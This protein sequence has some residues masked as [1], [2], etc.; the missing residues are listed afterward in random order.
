MKYLVTGGCGFIGSNLV[1]RLVDIGHEVV[2]VDNKSSPSHEHFYE[3]PKAKYHDLSIAGDAC[4]RVFEKFQPDVVFHLAAEVLIQNCVNDPQKT[5]H[6]NLQGTVNILEKC[7]HFKVKRLV[8]SSTASIYGLKNSEPFTEGMHPDCLNPY[9]ASKL[10]A[11]GACGL[12]SRLYG[13]DTVC[14]RYFNVYGPRQPVKGS[15]APIMAVFNR[16]KNNGENLT[17]VGDGNQTRDYV[18]VSD[19]ASANILAAEYSEPLNGEVF[20]VGTGKAYSVNDIADMYDPDGTNRSMLPAR[21]G[22]QRYVTANF[23]KIR[24]A[25]GWM[26]KVSLSQ[27]M[28]KN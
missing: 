17:I 28:D 18:H 16:Q 5:Y 3:N 24:K 15:Y 7:R 2:V 23:Q 4:S 6:T 9:S 8:L 1:D 10:A 12:Y 22:E 26:P 14:L 13:V 11:E 27:Y 25:L 19:V 21:E 20:N